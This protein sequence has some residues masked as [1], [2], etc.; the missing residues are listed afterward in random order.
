MR[1]IFA[2]QKFTKAF[3]EFGKC[4]ESFPWPTEKDSKEYTRETAKKYFLIFLKF[5]NKKAQRGNSLRGIKSSTQKLKKKNMPKNL[6]SIKKK[7]E[8]KKK[9]KKRR[10]DDLLANSALYPRPN[11]HVVDMALWN[12]P[13]VEYFIEEDERVKVIVLKRNREETIESFGR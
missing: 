9:K 1:A 12:L 5:Q 2:S 13:Y 7:G 11:T 6:K 3:H 10:L 8:K 4:N